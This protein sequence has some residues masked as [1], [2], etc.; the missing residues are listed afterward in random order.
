MSDC[1]FCKIIGGEIPSETVFE[2][3]EFKVVLDAFPAAKGHVLILPKNHVPNIFEIE[4]EQA[5]RLFHLASRVA[6]AMQS[7]DGLK[8]LNVL[9]NNGEIA[10]QTVFHFHLHLIP[11]YDGDSIKIGWNTNTYGEGEAA[12]IKSAI[13]AALQ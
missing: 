10:G 8:G 1:I 6:K 5:G 12:Q 3:E 11:R 7:L 9:Q 2:D 4:P 13:A